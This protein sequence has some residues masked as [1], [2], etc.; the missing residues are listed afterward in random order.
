MAFVQPN[1]EIFLSILNK[2]DPS[3]KPQWGTMTAQRMVEHLSDS[4]D[5]SLGVLRLELM[6]PEEK[7]ERAQ[8]FIESEHPLPKNV[9]VTFATTTTPLRYSELAISIDEFAQKWIAFEAYYTEFPDDKH[10]H[11]YFGALN[12]DLWSKLHSKHFTHHFEQFHLV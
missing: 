9:E 8:S 10:L 7:M 6:I 5:L 2:L 3:T 4:I 11:P 1:L 12:F